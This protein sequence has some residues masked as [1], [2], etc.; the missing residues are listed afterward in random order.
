MLVPTCPAW[1]EPVPAGRL[2]ALA[3]H[4]GHCECVLPTARADEKYYLILGAL[5]RGAGPY[6]VTVHTAAAA[7]PVAVPLESVP[8]DAAWSRRVEALHRRL[9][10]AYRQQPLAE[11]Y[12]PV[13]A[14]PRRR[15]FHLFIKERDFQDPESYVTVTGEL[16]RV[17]R[18]CQVYVDRNHAD[19]AALQPTVDDIVRTFD[20]HVYPRACQALGHALDVDRDG[21]FTIL[22]TGWLGKLANGKVA[23]D[24]FVRGSDFYRDLAA[25]YGNQCD[26]MYLNTDLQPGPHLRTLLA[27]EYT[28]A[29]I[30]SEHVFTSYLPEMP[31]QDE[32][33]W[34][35]EGLAHLVE[36]LHGYSWSN[37]DYRISAFLSA[38]ERYQLVVPDYYNAG[39][40][41]SHGNRGA[42][43]LFLRWCADRFGPDFLRELIQTNLAGVT[44]VEVT[45][46]ERF[47]DLFRQWSAVLAV[48]G[49]GIAVE[50]V[51][52]LEHISP[53]R[54]LAGRLLCGPRF[55]E[56]ALAEGRHEVQLTGT[57][58]AYLLLHASAG[59]RCRVTIT[60]EAAADL[61]VSLIRLPEQTGRISLRLTADEGRGAVRLELTAQDADVTLDA[62][63][64]ERLVPLANRP[65]DTSY[66]AASDPSGEQA[67]GA[68]FGERH[69][70]DGETRTSA[71]IAV[72]RRQ[73]SNDVFIIKVA[74]TDS[75]GHHLGAW[76]TLADRP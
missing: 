12:P 60:A 55:E 25:P 65:G 39:L 41:R 16:E 13:N 1:A 73:E 15:S 64:W 76:A 34:L 8:P 68:W 10:Q 24:G 46:Q 53:R 17:G 62:A 66:D 11:T 70:R 75:A 43:Y 37:L 74:A 22:L 5:A 56:V 4:D 23:L 30:F 44:N 47:A 52:P 19:R 6:R 32:E 27:H 29:V 63:A 54:P 51:A 26:M 2:L 71:A 48:S 33:G 50:G 59:E 49:T 58:C 45:T 36:D 28:H 31:R 69:V 18:H 72:P 3:V 35:N 57:S 67:V 14:P 38:P 61:Q 7:E 42:T 9:A 20:E 21:R 40:W